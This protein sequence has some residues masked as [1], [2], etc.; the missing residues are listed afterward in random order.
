MSTNSDDAPNNDNIISQSNDIGALDS[1]L[2]S[3][4]ID[5][6]DLSLGDSKSAVDVSDNRCHFNQPL[7]IGK[8]V[9]SF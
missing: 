2:E 1:N 4:Q 3:L 9:I 8:V 7:S 5:F 6:D